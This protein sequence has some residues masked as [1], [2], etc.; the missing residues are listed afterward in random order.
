MIREIVWLLAFEET[1]ESGA[2]SVRQRSP[3][4]ITNVRDHE[5]NSRD[6][7]SAV[8]ACAHTPEQGPTSRARAAPPPASLWI[9]KS[10]R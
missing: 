10:T 5:Q 8:L 9:R 2:Y 3:P 7:P 6:M 4:E 1:D